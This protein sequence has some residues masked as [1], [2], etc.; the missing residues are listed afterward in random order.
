MRAAVQSGSACQWAKSASSAGLSARLMVIHC[1]LI[2]AL[3]LSGSPVGKGISKKSPLNNPN[4]VRS[5]RETVA[6]SQNLGIRAETSAEA[7]KTI[8]AVSE[9]HIVARPDAATTAANAAPE[10]AMVTLPLSSIM[11]YTAAGAS[12]NAKQVASTTCNAPFRNLMATYCLRG[13]G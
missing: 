4:R 3:T 6:A 11:A 2:L 9:H 5:T 8:R 13:T 7:V 1:E 12:S 10:P